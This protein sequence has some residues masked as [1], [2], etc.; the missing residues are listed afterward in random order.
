VSQSIA[1]QTESSGT[2]TIQLEGERERLLEVYKLRKEI[3]TPFDF[4]ALYSWQE[5][6]LKMLKYFRKL[7]LPS[8][9]D[10]RILD[11]GCGSGATLRRFLDFGAEPQNCFGIDLVPKHVQAARQAL[12]NFVF[13]EG[14]AAQLPFGD[15]EFDI[16]HQA[17]VFTSI[18]DLKIKQAIACEAMRAL[19]PGGHLIWYDFA[20]SNPRNPNVRGIGHNEI[21]SL[22]SGC[23]LEFHRVTLAPPIARTAVRISPLLCQ[24]FWA[25]PFLRTHCLCFVQKPPSSQA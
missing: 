9:R 14:S 4:F 24:M 13:V 18:L 22:F 2:H 1:K 7:G 15:E 6:Q 21:R 16:V 25:F 19:R 5:R 20:Y 8:L 12:P 17:T 23:K 3:N 10:M 11:I